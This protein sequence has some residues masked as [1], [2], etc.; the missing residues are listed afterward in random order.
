MHA[1]SKN[2]VI[3]IRITV[4]IIILFYTYKFLVVLLAFIKIDM[5]SDYQNIL[6][7]ENKK[8]LPN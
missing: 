4:L 5:A 8:S 1:K 6:F 3:P 7:D 2:L